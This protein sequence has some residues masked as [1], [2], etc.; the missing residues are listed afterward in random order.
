MNNRK[1][2]AIN[3][4]S[5]FV[6][7]DIVNAEALDAFGGPGSDLLSHGLKPQYHRR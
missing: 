4:R 7:H 1:G 5:L 6:V 2:S 3:W